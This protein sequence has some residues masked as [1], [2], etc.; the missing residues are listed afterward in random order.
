[1][2]FRFCHKT[3]VDVFLIVR[4]VSFVIPVGNDIATIIMPL[5]SQLPIFKV[6]PTL[7]RIEKGRTSIPVLQL[8][9]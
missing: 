9:L 6:N 1:M 3:S 5:L 7:T 8:A 4:I 2:T